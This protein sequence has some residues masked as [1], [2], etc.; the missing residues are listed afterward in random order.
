L[1]YDNK[2]ST[3]AQVHARLVAAL[4][5]S[6]PL[7]AAS[8]AA[9][10][11]LAIGHPPAGWGGPDLDGLAGRLAQVLA[12][13]MTAASGPAV[14]VTVLRDAVQALAR[15]DRPGNER[16]LLTAL[17][18]SSFQ[19][20]LTVALALIRRGS[21]D[22]IGRSV[23]QWIGEAEAAGR[24][25]VAHQLGLALWFCPHLA[26]VDPSG[27]G[28]D[29]Y[30]RGLKLA[31]DADHNPLMF[32][33][34]LA[35]GFKLAAWACP[36]LAADGRAVGLLAGGV[37]FWYSRVCLVH[38]LGIRLASAAGRQATADA[39]GLVEAERAVEVAA[40]SDP[41]PLVRE[42][43]RITMAGVAAGRGVARFCWLAE[44]D[45]GRLNYQLDDEAMR[46]LGDVS[47]L[48]NLTYCAEPW[49][50][51]EWR[52][53][54]TAS[55]L[56]LCIRRPSGRQ[57]FMT[58]GCPSECS[59]GLCPYPSAS[60]RPRGRGELSA[61]FCQ[62]QH[63]VAERVGPGSWQEGRPGQAQV[64]FWL[65]AEQSLANRDGWEISL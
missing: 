5:G 62:A 30:V 22:L 27:R 54:G 15:A 25:D 64:D 10:L 28:D 40:V 4:T 38:A 49:S 17:H 13:R 60:R 44:S 59:F 20:R 36:D 43:A 19:V 48:L 39:G 9:G 46:L 65:Y 42:A 14:G 45:M 31:G 32:E 33:I 52:M 16:H 41:H 37:R 47:L 3:P 35:R 57:R 50:E 6:V 55:E 24:L 63:D 29:L 8:Q 51:Q 2:K 53:L 23:E 61:A 18:S 21:W 11:S 26:S 58:S 7:S 56:P 34:S 1:R 12:D